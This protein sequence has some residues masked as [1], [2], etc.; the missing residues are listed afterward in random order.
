MQLRLPGLL[1]SQRP[2]GNAGKEGGGG[3]QKFK[4]PLTGEK[5]Y[6]HKGVVGDEVEDDEA[7][8]EEAED[9]DRRALPEA[10]HRDGQASPVV[11]LGG[12]VR[13][14]G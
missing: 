3:G 7:G 12:A 5:A 10:P 2:R 8:D 9:G 6:R 11:R 13:T 14:H 1:E 4:V